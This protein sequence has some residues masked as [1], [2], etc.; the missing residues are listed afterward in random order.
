MLEGRVLRTNLQGELLHWTRSGNPHQLHHW[1]VLVHLHRLQDHEALRLKPLTDT[2]Q[3]TT[4]MGSPH[5]LLYSKVISRF[6]Y[7]YR[8]PA[9]S[10]LTLINFFA[11]L[12]VNLITV[13]LFLPIP[14]NSNFKSFATIQLLVKLSIQTSELAY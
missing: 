2:A 9:I 13:L 1:L 11:K 4:L 6:Y 7:E 5:G 10:V 3:N 8:Q 12:S 14:S